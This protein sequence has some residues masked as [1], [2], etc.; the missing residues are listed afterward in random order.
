[1][2]RALVSKAHSFSHQSVQFHKPSLPLLPQQQIP[3]DPTWDDF[4]PACLLVTECP[5]FKETP[6]LNFINMYMTENCVTYN[7]AY[8]LPGQPA[9]GLK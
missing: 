5:K 1:M 4:Y 6:F 8:V 2:C 7:K 3:A 9:G